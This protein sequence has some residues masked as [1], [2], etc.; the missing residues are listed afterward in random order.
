MVD[1]P[2][3]M[4][5][6]AMISGVRML[7]SKTLCLPSRPWL[8]SASPLSAAK[9]M[10]VLSAWPDLLQ[11]REDPP[12]L[13]VQ[14]RDQAVVLGQLVANHRLGPR[15]GGQVLVAAASHHAVV[16]RQL[17][18]EVRR[19]RRQVAVVR[20]AVARRRLPRIVRRG[21]G[22]VGEERL[23]AVVL[24]QELDGRVGEQ[25][26]GEFLA[27]AFGGQLAV[28]AQ[29]AHRDF[30]VVR[31]AAEHD[32]FAALERAQP[33]RLAVV[34]FAGGERDV[35]VLAEQFRQQLRALERRRST[36]NHV[37]PLISIARLGT[38][39]APLLP[40]KM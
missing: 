7:C 1:L 27:R 14:V 38:Q 3:G 11:R 34:P 39:T 26:A 20:L 22:D 13:L 2:R 12:D 6:P 32:G 40:P 23:L 8:P 25:L 18:Q 24:L 37:L 19:Q 15:P 33:G 10:I 5:G 4:P 28:G 17:R 30:G 31:H 35:A 16:E 9:M 21:E 29:I 36:W